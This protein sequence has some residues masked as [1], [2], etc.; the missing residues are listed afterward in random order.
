MTTADSL[1]ALGMLLRDGRAP[2][3]TTADWHAVLTLADAALV[4]PA[5]AG[6]DL[7]PGD[8]RVYV[9][10]VRALTTERARALRAQL[11]ELGAA[12]AAGGV[13]LMLLKGAAALPDLPEAALGDRL[14]GDLDLAVRPDAL[15]AARR[16]LLDLGYARLDAGDPDGRTDGTWARPA[17]RAGVD[18]H[19][20]VMPDDTLLPMAELWRTA[21]PVPAAGASTVRPDPT[22]RLAHL[23]LHEMV[24]HQGLREGWISPRALLD[25]RGLMPAGPDWAWLQSHFRARGVGLALTVPLLAA[26]RLLGTGWPLDARP[27]PATRLVAARILRGGDAGI[28]GRT[29]DIAIAVGEALSAGHLRRLYGQGGGV[30]MLR[31]RHIAGLP[32]R[33][34]TRHRA[35]RHPAVRR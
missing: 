33:L 4:T 32:A 17:D 7:P 12:F 24:H 28:M 23:L 30:A 13:D 1:A 15:H 9:D 19:L 34:M 20:R 26:D 29:V 3:L 25:L 22:R 2:G 6:C 21:E 5:L 18:L 27:D 10:G 8:I 35:T 31:L 16:A 11:A 14:C